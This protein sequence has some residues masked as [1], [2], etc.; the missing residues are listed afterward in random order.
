MICPMSERDRTIPINCTFYGTNQ[1]FINLNGIESRTKTAGTNRD[2]IAAF[3]NRTDLVMDCDWWRYLLILFIIGGNWWGTNN[4]KNWMNPLYSSTSFFS[5]FFSEM[6]E[7][8][9]WFLRT[10]WT[11]WLNNSIPTPFANARKRSFLW[12]YAIVWKDCFI[13]DSL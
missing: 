9:W 4:C 6:K 2:I 11:V 8:W 12:S 7:G 3:T 5:H 1:F 10:Q 13:D